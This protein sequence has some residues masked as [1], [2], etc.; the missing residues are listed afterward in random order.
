MNYSKR[1]RGDSMKKRQEKKAL[2]KSANLKK[3]KEFSPSVADGEKVAEFIKK[4]VE[5]AIHG[6]CLKD[7]W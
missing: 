2:L 4:A 6:I 3:P 5:T 7:E 1:S